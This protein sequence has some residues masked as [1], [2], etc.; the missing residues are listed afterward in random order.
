MQFFGGWIVVA[1]ACFV[2]VTEQA[3]LSSTYLLHLE[4]LPILAFLRF[5]ACLPFTFYL[6]PTT[7]LL[8]L[9][10][11]SESSL[12]LVHSL[13]QFTLLQESLTQTICLLLLLSYYYVPLLL[14]RIW[15]EEE[16]I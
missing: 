7:N 5:L 14:Q 8:P 13:T 16:A 15:E 12:L 10:Y 3:P 2:C 1:V 9:L 11:S 6:H 4:T